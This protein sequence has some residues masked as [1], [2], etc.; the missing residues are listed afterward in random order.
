MR[1]SIVYFEELMLEENRMK[2]KTKQSF[3]Y[4]FTFT[5]FEPKNSKERVERVWS[6]C[7][8]LTDTIYC[9]FI[10]LPQIADIYC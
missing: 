7:M 1:S 2:R 8:D 9:S 6:T 10:I 3:S 5:Y 4:S